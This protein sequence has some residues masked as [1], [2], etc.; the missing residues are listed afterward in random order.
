NKIKKLDLQGILSDYAFTGVAGS[1]GDGGPAL[2]AQYA[3]GYGSIAVSAGGALYAC[4]LYGNT[5]R[6][7]SAPFPG[8]Q[9][10]AFSLASEDGREVYNFDSQGRHLSTVDS[11]TASTRHQFGYDSAG[12]LTSITDGDSNVTTITRGTNTATI[13]GP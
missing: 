2:T 3:S 11:L 4:D 12:R 10:A 7:V 5:I 9:G 6:Q 1:S 13:T 8:F